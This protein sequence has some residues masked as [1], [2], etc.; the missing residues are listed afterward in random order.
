[1]HLWPFCG[2]SPLHGCNITVCRP[3]A[4]ARAAMQPIAEMHPKAS[5]PQ[6]YIQTNSQVLQY[7]QHQL[8]FPGSQLPS[9]TCANQTAEFTMADREDSHHH[10]HQLHNLTGSCCKTPAK[11]S[12]QFTNLKARSR[13]YFQPSAVSGSALQVSAALAIKPISHLILRNY[14]C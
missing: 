10:E 11:E 6:P 2:Q 1:M 12:T 3:S 5:T 4:M 13:P 9:A 14:F 8:T 7:R